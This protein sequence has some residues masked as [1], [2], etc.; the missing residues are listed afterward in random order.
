VDDP[1][2]SVVVPVYN[3]APY[4]EAALESVVSQRHDLLE[5]IVVDDG[6][7]DESA[8]V[9]RRCGARVIAAEHRGIAHARNLGVAAVRGGLVAFLD[10]DDLWTENSLEDRLTSL[11]GRPQ[12]DFVF[13]R[14]R[15]FVD[16]DD[17][18]PSWLPRARVEERTGMMST[19][20]VR[21]ELF[22]RTGPFD[23][24]LVI[25]ED[26]DWVARAYD[27]GA[28]SVCLDGIFALHRLHAQSA[29]AIHAA[30]GREAL[31][32]LVR[33]SIDRKRVSAR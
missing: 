32:R 33:S 15:D 12:V 18:P 31:K 25:G 9:A 10:A 20:V 5:S 17:P 24:T 16:A 27:R 22:D 26:L 2:V 8:D 1:R 3:S 29:T 21:R 28:S 6:S 13:G 30:F 4:L 23:E 14:M 11:A 7:T 19:F